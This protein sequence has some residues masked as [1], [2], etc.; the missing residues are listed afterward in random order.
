MR[1][2]EADIDD[3]AAI[4]RVHVDSWRTTYA[5]IVPEE[6]LISQLSYEG[7]E[8]MWCKSLGDSSRR[9]FV[10]VA[11]EER[12]EVVGFAAGGPERNGDPFY[13][14]EIYAIYLLQEFQRRGIGR[15]LALVSARKMIEAGQKSMLVW[16]LSKNPSRGFY[17]ALGGELLSEKP[18]EV[19]GAKLT[20]VAYGWKDLR[21]L[22]M[23]GM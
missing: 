21:L 14:G 7:R 3:A 20:E 17:E 18:I 4:A 9:G 12:G 6:Q 2:R 8:R 5:G 23:P 16:V 1:V 15:R 19:G 13:H 22:L 10:Y 11:E